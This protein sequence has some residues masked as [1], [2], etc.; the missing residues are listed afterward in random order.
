MPPETLIR[1]KTLTGTSEL[2]AWLGPKR[3]L[4][5]PQYN[6]DREPTMA[7]QDELARTPQA[8]PR[9]RGQCG[10]ADKRSA[11]PRH[12]AQRCDVQR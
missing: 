2:T 8:N 7:A 11:R 9:Q 4:M 3:V 6:E 1:T 12:G 10:S 5:R